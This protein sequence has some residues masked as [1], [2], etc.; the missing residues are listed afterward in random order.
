MLSRVSI[1]HSCWPLLLLT[2]ALLPPCFFGPTDP[3]AVRVNIITMIWNLRFFLL[4]VLSSFLP[5]PFV[6]CQKQDMHI[7][8]RWQHM[9]VTSIKDMFHVFTLH[10]LCIHSA[11]QNV[12]QRYRNMKT[13]S[14][15]ISRS[16]RARSLP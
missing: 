9:D 7:W 3:D 12:I 13:V 6:V 11:S 16:V 10:E 15:Y 4:N 2:A 5:T 8:W 1:E 14:F